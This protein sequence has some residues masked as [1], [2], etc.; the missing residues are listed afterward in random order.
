[1]MEILFYHLE[2]RTLE[3]VLPDLLE[4]TLERGLKAAVKFGSEARLKALDDLLW[5]FRED[6]FLPHAPAGEASDAAQPILLT[7]TDER[8]NE[9]AYQFVVAGA[10]MPDLGALSA[11]KPERL[12]LMFDGTDP[13]A[14]DAARK[15]WKS[16]RGSPYIL[17]YWQQNER[18]RWEKKA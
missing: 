11:P 6:S 16:L 1:M 12:I 13:D 7:L 15:D 5:T 17:T 10:G 4:K 14:L 18:G 9:A 3:Q 8:P 2:R